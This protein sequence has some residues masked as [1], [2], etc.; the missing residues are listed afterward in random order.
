MDH[1]LAKEVLAQRVAGPFS[2]PP[3]PNFRVSPISII[4]SRQAGVCPVDNLLR[5]FSVRGSVP[6]PLFQHLNGDPV[7][8]SEFDE[9]LARVIKSCELDSTRYK[10]HSFRIGAASHASARGYSDSHKL[11]NYCSNLG[12]IKSGRA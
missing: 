7:T 6:G 2:H 12:H 1:Y 8:R 5:F 11:G 3:L 10:G 9:W 4:I